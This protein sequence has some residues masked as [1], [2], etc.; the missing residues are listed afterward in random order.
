M[1]KSWKY[2]ALFFLAASCLAGC[3]QKEVK[4]GD[5]AGY[6]EEIGRAHV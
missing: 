4:P 1:R 6:E 2:A 3:R 5:I